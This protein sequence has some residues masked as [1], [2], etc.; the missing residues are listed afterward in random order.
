[1]HIDYDFLTTSLGI[2][3]GI[4]YLDLSQS[5]KD[6]KTYEF[7]TNL[8]PMIDVVAF[9]QFIFNEKQLT[10]VHRIKYHI[11]YVGPSDPNYRTQTDYFT[12]RC[13]KVR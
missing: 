7:I 1:M 8:N 4:R 5:D 12:L 3:F 6:S 11:N 2:S 13:L 9:N 10:I